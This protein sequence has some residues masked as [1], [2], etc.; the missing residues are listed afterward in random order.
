MDGVIAEIRR[1]RPKFG[2]ISYEA[3]E[4]EIFEEVPQALSGG[5]SADARSMS[6]GRTRQYGGSAG[7]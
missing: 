3:T 4:N 6:A 2:R 5:R 7:E 1:F